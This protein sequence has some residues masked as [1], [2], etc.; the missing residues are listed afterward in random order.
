M[1]IYSLGRALADPN[2]ARH[3][4]N[5]S[6]AGW[7]T[8]SRVCSLCRASRSGSDLEIYRARTGR[9]GWPAAAFA[10]AAVIVGRGGGKSRILALIAVYSGCLPFSA[11]RIRPRLGGDASGCG[12]GQG[13]GAGDLPVCDRV[14]EGGA[15]VPKAARVPQKAF[16][17][18]LSGHGL[19]GVLAA[20]NFSA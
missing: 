15:D 13:A 6:W 4:R 9:T 17:L 5:K 19:R 20:R 3:S 10:E 7:K 16:Q 14:I 2:S 8:F 11:R 12:G 1:P 18:R